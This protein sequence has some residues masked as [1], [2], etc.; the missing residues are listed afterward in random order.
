MYVGDF[1]TGSILVMENETIVRTFRGYNGN[2]VYL[3]YILFDM[4]GLM[5]TSCYKNQF[6]LYYPNGTY[7][8]KNFTI[9]TG[10]KY[11]GYDSNDH[12]I[13]ISYFQINIYN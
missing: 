9:P 3:T 5:A 11:I 7:V 12:F 1:L 13:Q 2:T 4:C 6:Y 8:G 10:P